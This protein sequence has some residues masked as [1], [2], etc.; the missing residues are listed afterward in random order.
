MTRITVDAVIRGVRVFIV[1]P[2]AVTFEIDFAQQVVTV[3]VSESFGH[4]NRC[5]K[6]VA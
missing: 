2:L 4:E 3:S 5:Y 1:S 6:S